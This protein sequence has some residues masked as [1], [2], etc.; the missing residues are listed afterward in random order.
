MANYYLF[1]SSIVGTSFGI[2]NIFTRIVNIAVPI[3]AEMK[4]DSIGQWVFII[5]MATV[6]MITFCIIDKKEEPE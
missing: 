6:L 5:V 2:C 1:P 4:P 3:V